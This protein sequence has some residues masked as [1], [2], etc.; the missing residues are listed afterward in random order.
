MELY[1]L[2]KNQKDL[3]QIETSSFALERDLQSLIEAN[4]ETLFGLGFYAEW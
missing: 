2:E 4:V 3:I 1:K